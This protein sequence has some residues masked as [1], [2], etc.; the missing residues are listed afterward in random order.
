MN[1]SSYLFDCDV[2]I[3]KWY[4]AFGKKVFLPQEHST[5]YIPT[6]ILGLFEVNL[7]HYEPNPEWK[8][9]SATS[10]RHLENTTDNT[11]FPWIEYSFVMQR[12]SRMYEAT[13]GIPALGKQNAD[14]VRFDSEV[15][16]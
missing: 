15:T 11:T 10:S 5:L 8:L 13:M 4:F 1:Q 14:L 7:F 12:H 3:W 6:V 2:R 16:N 9:L